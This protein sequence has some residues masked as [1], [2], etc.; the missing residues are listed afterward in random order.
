MFHRSEEGVQNY[1]IKMK[2]VKMG[3]GT[4]SYEIFLHDPDS[5]YDLKLLH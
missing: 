2:N 5:K 4:L 1:Q 3:T